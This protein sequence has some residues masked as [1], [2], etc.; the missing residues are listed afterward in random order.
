MYQIQVP[1]PMVGVI[2]GK[3]GECINN[4]QQ[5]CGIRLQFLNGKKHIVKSK[6]VMEFIN[7]VMQIACLFSD[8]L[9]VKM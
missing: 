8:I 4:I 5:T 7:T 3:N 9:F 1:R 6:T 2:I